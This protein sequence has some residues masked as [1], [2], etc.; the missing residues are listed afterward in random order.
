M[1]S[2]IQTS[3]RMAMWRLFWDRRVMAPEDYQFIIP[4]VTYSLLGILSLLVIWQ[5]YQNQ[6]L[7]GRIR[8]VD[9]WDISGIRLFLHASTLDGRTCQA[10]REA[11]G[12]VFAPSLATKKHFSTL[13]HPCMNPGGCRCLI[14]GLYGGWPE[15]QT[16][17]KTLRRATGK[18]LLKLDGHEFLALFE[19]PWH[20]SITSAGD[21]LTIHL[22]EGLR[23]DQTDPEGAIFRYRC[24]ID[25]ARGA[26]DLYL[27]VP[28][29]TRLVDSLARLNRHEEALAVIQQ[30]EQ[31]FPRNKRAFYYPSDYQRRTMTIRKRGLESFIQE[32]RSKRSMRRDRYPEDSFPVGA[33]A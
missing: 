12:T 22:V 16:V 5:Y 33:S 11:H 28:A 15:A 10:C 26:R 13:R 19:G 23:L 7:A 29:Y 30:F 25:Q 20:Q 17:V 24:V 14:V 3:N 31:Q 32:N 9:F 4:E 27:L 8:V 21:R 18:K 2:L 1:F 6:V